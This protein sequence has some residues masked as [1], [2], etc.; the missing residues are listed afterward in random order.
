MN[1]TA[2]LGALVTFA[3]H[4]LCVPVAHADAVS[5]WVG[6]ADRALDGRPVAPPLQA[7]RERSAPALTALAIFEAVNAIDPRYQSYLSFP[8]ASAP[9]LDE[10]AAAAGHGVLS[11]LYPERSEALD[12]ALA[13]ALAHIEPGPA[14]DAGI[15]VGE[16]AAQ[17]ALARPMFEGPA[18][19]PYRPAG[20]VGRFVNPAPPIIAPWSLRAQFFFLASPEEPMPPPPPELASERYARDLNETR[21]LGG[22]GQP[23]AT[24]DA[25]RRARFLAG[26]SLDPVLH[27]AV[28]ERPRL[29]ERA[30]LWALVRMA[31]HDAN[32][33]ISIAK[34]R[35]QTW[36]PIN[37]IRNADRDENPKTA[38]DPDWTPVMPTPNHPEYPCGHCTVSALQAALLEPYASAPVEVR[39]ESAA[40]GASMTFS[41]WQAFINAA[42]LARIQ[43][44][45]HL[46]FSNE[47]GQAMG[48]RIAA[49]AQE[50]FAPKITH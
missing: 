35:Y 8:R 37:A 39:S 25:L 7:Q 4:L 19:S 34:M 47:A 6:L 49:I 46:R 15:T 32:A 27:R 29:V 31:E 38:R 3:S 11:A 17:V 45:M 26:F 10:A 21:T 9:A 40:L 48:R 30:R 44:G 36:R 43:G 12:D 16:R 33:M 28:Q 5:D 2:R 18:P 14:R 42:S 22:V 1:R 23:G 13:L 41:N 50:R 24:P 20:D